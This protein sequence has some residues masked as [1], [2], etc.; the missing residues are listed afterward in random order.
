MTLPVHPGPEPLN[1][2][3]P[4]PSPKKPDPDASA[5]PIPD[6]EGDADDDGLLRIIWGWLG[7]RV[8]M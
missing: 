7:F 5:G 8:L 3:P 1:P 2:I 4:F 6:E